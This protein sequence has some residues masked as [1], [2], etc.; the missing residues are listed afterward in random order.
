M[1]THG[2]TC[3]GFT[4]GVTGTI[5]AFTA[6]LACGDGVRRVTMGGIAACAPD[7]VVGWLNT[8]G[9]IRDGLVC[10]TL[11]GPELVPPVLIACGDSPF[12]PTMGGAAACA[13]DMVVGWLNTTGDI[14]DG[15][16]CVTLAGIE[17]APPVLIACGDSPCCTTTGCCTA[18]CVLG[19]TGMNW[20]DATTKPLFTLDGRDFIC[21]A[22]VCTLNADDAADGTTAPPDA[23]LLVLDALELAALLL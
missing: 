1:L 11:A 12:C 13:P 23:A 19:V 2:F 20:L 6:S 22:I 5:G 16:V 21:G 3:F 4:V 15:L 9:D 7:M 10:V 17:L 8:T 18:A 14:R